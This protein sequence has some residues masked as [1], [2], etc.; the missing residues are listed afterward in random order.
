MGV[1][2]PGVDPPPLLVGVETEP[3]TGVDGGEP[4]EVRGTTVLASPLAPLSSLLKRRKL[5]FDDCLLE[6]RDFD[7]GFGELDLACPVGCTTRE[8]TETVPF[9]VLVVLKERIP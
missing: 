9:I 4:K 8:A 7:P 5:I 6:S 2:R 3:E 1:Q